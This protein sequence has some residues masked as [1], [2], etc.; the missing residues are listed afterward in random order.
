M[1][2]FFIFYAKALNDV[3]KEFPF[4]KNMIPEIILEFLFASLY[5]ALAW[6]FIGSILGNIF[7]TKKE[8]VE[9]IPLYPIEASSE[10]GSIRTDFSYLKVKKVNEKTYVSY[11]TDEDAG[12]QA[13]TSALGENIYVRSRNA[14]APYPESPSLELHYKKAR[15]KNWIDTLFFNYLVTQKDAPPAKADLLDEY[16]KVVFIVPEDTLHYFFNACSD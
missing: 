11:I 12:M 7:I 1:I 2:Y 15:E 10:K 9:R 3:R 8:V 5:G 14:D 13:H 4:T 6:C 16:D